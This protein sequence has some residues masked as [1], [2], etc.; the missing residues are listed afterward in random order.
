MLILVNPDEQEPKN[1]IEILSLRYF[2]K[3]YKTRLK[4][5]WFNTMSDRIC[6]LQA[7]MYPR[8]ETQL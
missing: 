1:F 4:L 2:K 5:F 6:C 3:K 8:L 7:R